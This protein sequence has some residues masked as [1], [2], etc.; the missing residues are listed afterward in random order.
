MHRPQNHLAVE[1]DD[2]VGSF[3]VRHNGHVHRQH[4]M[5]IEAGLRL[6]KRNQGLD[7]NAGAC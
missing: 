4:L 3:S 6:L 1:V 2:V 7:E 5:H